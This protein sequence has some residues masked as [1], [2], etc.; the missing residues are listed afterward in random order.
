MGGG[1]G[2]GGG[3]GKYI[4]SRVTHHRSHSMSVSKEKIPALAGI[5]T[6]QSVM[7]RAAAMR[8]KYRLFEQKHLSILRW[9]HSIARIVEA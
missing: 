2:G 4:G 1:G 5:E 9:S 7:K 3:D 6:G 8:I